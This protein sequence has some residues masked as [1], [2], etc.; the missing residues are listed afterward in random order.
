MGGVLTAVF[1]LLVMV[2]VFGILIFIHE[3]GHFFTARKCGVAIKEFAIGM[4][5]TLFSW[6]SKK[7]ETK[8]ALRAFPIGGF[9]SMVGEDE[10]SDDENAFCNKKVWQRML[11]TVAGPL[12][13]LLLGFILM[14]AVVLM[15]GPVATTTVDKF[16]P[17][18]LSSEKLQSG[19][20]ILEV[21]GTKVQSGNELIYEIMNKGYEPIDLVVKRNGEKITLE[22]VVFP[23]FEDQGV[24]FGDM[25]FSI[26]LEEKTFLS[27]ITHTF[28][29]SVST[30]KMVVDSL[31]GL[32]SGRFGIDA[33]SGPIGVAEVVG[34]AAKEGLMNF[35]YISTVLTIN[36]GVFNLIPFPALDGGRFLFLIIE[37]I[38]RKPI[39]KN[40]EAYINFAGIVLLFGLMIFISFKDVLKLFFR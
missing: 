11:I 22:D 29:R 14:F 8:Y 34:E 40:V 5:P 36:L 30:V 10:A 12:M 27:T 37:A 32:L 16:A 39:N 15:Q 13:N 25:D 31:V 17:E 19:D 21:G 7:Y 3:F 23:T 24:V 20:E 35:L 4:G 18:A 6:K 26:L 28:T 1:Y 2:F 38:R 33:M 9:V